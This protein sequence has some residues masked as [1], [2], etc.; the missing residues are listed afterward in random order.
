MA[1]V[2]GSMKLSTDILKEMKYYVY[3]LSDPTDNEIFYVGKGKGNR[4]FSH[5]TDNGDNPK[6]KK[7]KEIRSKGEEPKIELL[8]HGV[9][10]EI[11]IKKIEA[12]IIDLIGKNKLTN[13]VGGYES[14][15]FGRMDLEQIKA[16]Y[17]S[18]VANISENVLLIK[19]TDSFRYNMEPMELY[20]YTRGIWKVGPKRDRVDYAFAVYDGIIQETYKVLEW[21][22]AGTT[23]TNRVDTKDWLNVPRWEFIGSISEEM[24]KKYRYKSARHYYTLGNRNPIRYTF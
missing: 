14:S 19:L 5:L 10:D 17:S 15:D 12:A 21:F 9:N 24:R 7:I 4:A 16:K 1:S 6:A 13:K 23:F 11:T 3:L 20:D 2:E 22:E 18:D 8:V